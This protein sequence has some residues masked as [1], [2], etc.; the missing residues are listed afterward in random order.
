MLTCA[1]QPQSHVASL[2][3]LTSSSSCD[4]ASGYHHPLLTPFPRFSLCYA[5]LG[6]PFVAGPESTPS[7]WG[8]IHLNYHPS[9]F[10]MQFAFQNLCLSRFSMTS[11]PATIFAT[12]LDRDNRSW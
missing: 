2:E 11:C 9:S 6:H 3:C 7:K 8:D 12:N 10:D 4:I 5:S 1:K